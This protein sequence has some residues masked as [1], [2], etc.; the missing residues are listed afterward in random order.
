M[1]DEVIVGLPLTLGRGRIV[2]GRLDQ[3]ESVD[4]GY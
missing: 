3:P 2:M 1:D 4:L